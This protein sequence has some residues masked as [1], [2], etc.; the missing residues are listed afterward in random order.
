[1]DEIALYDDKDR[2]PCAYDVLLQWITSSAAAKLQKPYLT[3]TTKLAPWERALERADILRFH[4]PEDGTCDVKFQP[5]DAVYANKDGVVLESATEELFLGAR[6]CEKWVIDKYIQ[7]GSFGRG[8]S[9]VNVFTHQAVFIKA[10]RSFS[11]RPQ[12]RKRQQPPE[13]AMAKQ[14]A[15]IRK[16]IEVLLH[17]KFQQV[18]S[19]PGVTN[20]SLCYGTVSV[21]STGFKGEMFFI[22]TEDLCTGGE[23][24][25]FLCPPEPPYVRSF[26]EAAARRIFRQLAAGVNHLHSCGAYHRDLKLENIVVDGEFNVKI[27]DFGSLKFD[28]QLIEIAADAGNDPMMVAT[29]YGGVGTPGYTPPEVRTG[30]EGGRGGYKPAPFDVWSVGTILFYLVAGEE[31]FKKIGGGLCFQLIESIIL[32]RDPKLA[33][34]MSEPGVVGK[35]TNAPLHTKLWEW[36]ESAGGLELSEELKH[37]INRMLDLDPEHRISMSTVMTCE[38]L[39]EEDADD[40]AFVKEMRS[41]PIAEGKD[42]LLQLT[43]LDSDAE[44]RKTIVASIPAQSDGTPYKIVAGTDEFNIGECDD[45]NP[46]YT[47]HFLDNSEA[48]VRWGSGSLSEWLRF[49]LEMKIQLHL[50]DQEEADIES[51]AKE[52]RQM[53]ASSS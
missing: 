5:A 42:L 7:A 26:T 1:M 47:I 32:K 4:S 48:V 50:R 38:W 6:L 13:A 18:V 12:R 24:F 15:A 21:P 16:E 11:D 8:W 52:F 41:R 43:W 53:G 23:L 2:V 14:E 3:V 27:M 22:E 25:N 17:P 46:L 36:L 28:D 20:N 45:G 44:A 30:R 39:D 29:T 19:H 9:G 34:F 10:F 51:A 49:S 40:D 31:V 33:G 35:L 37:L